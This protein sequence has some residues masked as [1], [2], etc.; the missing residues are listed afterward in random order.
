MVGQCTAQVFSVHFDTWFHLL[1][2]I[3]QGYASAEDHKMALQ[4]LSTLIQKVKAFPELSRDMGANK[5]KA[6][7]TVL[8]AQSS[9]ETKESVVKCLSSCMVH[10]PGPTSFFKS[11]LQTMLT[12][13]L[14]RPSPSQV[15]TR[16][17]AQLARCGRGSHRDN[18]REEWRDQYDRTLSALKFVLSKLY[19]GL[20]SGE[21]VGE[22]NVFVLPVPNI[23]P[24]QMMCLVRRFTTLCA[25]LGCLLR[26]PFPT[27]VPVNLGEILQFCCRTLAVQPET[28]TARGSTD[29]MLLLSYLPLMYSSAIS[30]LASL[31]ICGKHLL[32]PS[33]R[34]LVSLCVQ[35]L[36]STRGHRGHSLPYRQVRQRVYL[37]LQLWMQV[38][39][40]SAM[41]HFAPDG[42]LGDLL[43]QIFTDMDPQQPEALQL[44][45]SAQRMDPNPP[46]QKKRR[47]N[48]AHHEL[49]VNARAFLPNTEDLV[50]SALKALNEIV[51][52]VAIFM[53]DN[54]L[55][56]LKDR[57][58]R[59]VSD[60]QQSPLPPYTC[61]PVRQMMY[62]VLQSTVVFPCRPD[63]THVQYALSL[64][65]RGVMDTEFSV[66]V[67]CRDAL[68]VCRTLIH[69][70]VPCLAAP[71]HRP[72]RLSGLPEPVHASHTSPMAPPPAASR[73]PVVN[74]TSALETVAAFPRTSPSLA[75]ASL[76]ISDPPR[77]PESL[78]D[79]SSSRH[80]SSDRPLQ[81]TA[82]S[83]SSHREQHQQQKQKEGESESESVSSEGSEETFPPAGMSGG[84]DETVPVMK[85]EADEL[86]SSGDEEEVS[87]T[88]GV[89]SAGDRLPGASSVETEMNAGVSS[90][91]SSFVPCEAEPDEDE[92]DNSA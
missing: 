15:Y 79:A 16:C 13:V 62:T 83:F 29:H 25:C 34:L 90:M 52:S 31:I 71:V 12:E 39:G 44:E 87:R 38:A 85:E 55:S 36:V 21:E 43:T 77:S 76:G 30:L 5:V 33:G 53:E 32:L 46:P 4:I 54:L 49:S 82:V 17:Y 69:P 45:K 68:K 80:I 72:P 64:F 37:T 42:P 89:D 27:S 14:D 11:R 66:S 48:R 19:E 84:V 18:Q 8:L 70:Q 2:K 22:D 26:E 3:I 60:S 67:T 9:E 40:S 61:T 51:N 78:P 50:M 74:S 1:V 92:E 63:P 35:C 23:Q 57:V 47:K 56:R 20:E 24:D 73:T 28:L 10:F 75:S 59:L 6:V 88:S 41:T 65:Q 7:L 91:L 86:S 81:G 58:C